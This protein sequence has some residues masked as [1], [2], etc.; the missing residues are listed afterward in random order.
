MILI[1][2]LAAALLIYLS[3]ES[4]RG[5]LDYLNYFKQELIKPRSNFTPFAT[6]IA[7][8]KGLDEGLREN[9]NSLLTQAY[10][11]YEVLFV[12]DD[13]NDP[14]SEVIEDISSKSAKNAKTIIASKAEISSQ[15]VENLS[16]AI[17]HADERSEVFAFVD[18]DTRPS[19][20]W[21]ADLV[22]PLENENIGAATGYRWFF[23]AKATIASE[24]R[25]SWN[26]SI[27][28]ALGPDKNSNFC[29]G[30]SMAIRR[31]TFDAIGIRE[32][33]KGTLS[34]DFAVTR[35]MNA[36]GKAIYFVPKALTPSIE[37]CTAAEL[38]EFTNRQMKITRVYARRLWLLSFFGSG[39]FNLVMIWSLFNLLVLPRFGPAWSASAITL[40]SVKV[41]SVGKAW[42]RLNALRL[43][44]PAYNRRIDRQFV[45]QLILWLFT[46]A[47]FLINSAAALV[48]RRIKWRGV[49]YEMVSPNETTLISRQ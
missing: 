8:C 18:S 24:L 23:S 40:L 35:A 33:W 16:E 4:F 15:K 29:W 6:V 21:L 20:N 1:Y 45:P 44:L 31:D 46:P 5:G 19:R 43:A 36:A 22:A 34:D 25:S 37:S 32:K 41:L 28:S 11:S 17:L 2:Y 27:A 10:P 7:P 3:Y 12:I 9:L 42:L 14:A 26:A 30:G 39:L 47:I 48:S 49:E 38:F 13:P